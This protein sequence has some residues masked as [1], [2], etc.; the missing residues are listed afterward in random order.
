MEDRNTAADRT[1]NN[2][3]STKAIGFSTLLE[4]NLTG[5]LNQRLIY[6]VDWS[7]A[8]IAAVRDGTVPPPGETFPAKPFPDTIYTLSGAFIQSEIETGKFSIIP[9]LRFD[10]YHLSPSS[11]GYFGGTAV[12]LSGQAV[13]PR[14][15]VVWQ[16]SPSFAP[17]GQIAKGFRAPTPDQVN[18]GFTNLA[19]GYTS[20]GNANLKAENAESVEVGFRGNSE[21]IRYSVAAFENRYKDF[22]SLQAVG[23]A[24][25]PANPIVFQYINLTNAHIHGIEARAAWQMGKLWKAHAGVAYAKGESKANGVTTPLDTIQPLKTVLGIQYDDDTWG[26]RANLV[27][28]EGKNVRHISTSTAQFAPPSYTVLDFGFYWK[29]ARNLAV[30]ANLNNALDTKYWRWNDTRG[31]PSSST[32]KDAYTAPGRNVQVS[33]RYNF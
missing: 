33:A 27:Y 5:I 20:I 31:L 4:S 22:I 15:G 19:S 30:N 29:P 9:G 14:L 7:K 23:G 1:R 26:G 2:S 11:A 32:V 16:L 24:G 21:S 18:N 25:T 17:Y 12:A 28:S 6:G 8:E 10:H 13:T 3:Y